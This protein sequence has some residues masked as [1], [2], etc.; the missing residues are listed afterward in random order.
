MPE[1]DAVDDE[2][3]RLRHRAF[4]R[5]GT[6]ADRERLAALEA[7][8]HVHPTAEPLED[9]GVRAIETPPEPEQESGL[10][11]QHEAASPW[12][13]IQVGVLAAIAGLL[14]GLGVSSVVAFVPEED[15][16]PAFGPQ[17]DEELRGSSLEVFSR[18]ASPRD[19]GNGFVGFEPIFDRLDGVEARFLGT[20]GPSDATVFAVRGID[21]GQPVVCLAIMDDATAAAGCSPLSDFLADGLI[22]DL[23]GVAARWGPFGDDLWV[24][25]GF[26]GFATGGRD[27]RV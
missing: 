25:T 13:R 2:L 3:G 17:F 21:S 22:I 23:N 7:T 8:R 1:Q 26:D 24:T 18:T 19:D 12:T 16:A 11:G 15:H 5:H 20:V 10:D 14:V 4:S 27:P 9:D 6:A